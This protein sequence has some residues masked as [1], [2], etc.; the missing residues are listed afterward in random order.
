VV[1]AE[2][3]FFPCLG[4]KA[5]ENDDGF[6]LRQSLVATI[7]VSEAMGRASVMRVFLQRAAHH[8]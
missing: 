6:S 5:P 8:N 7:A 1:N 4:H 3:G 2:Q